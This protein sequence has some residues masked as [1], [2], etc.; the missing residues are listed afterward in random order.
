MNCGRGRQERRVAGAE[1]Q[2]ADG[3]P[4]ITQ[5]E[6]PDE[7]LAPRL[8]AAP[9]PEPERERH[10]GG[11]LTESGGARLGRGHPERE[12]QRGERENDAVDRIERRGRGALGP[13]ADEP[14]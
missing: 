1:E 14:V 4:R 8:M 12:R 6:A 13:L 9:A 11:E 7:R 3:E 5:M 10:A 2:E